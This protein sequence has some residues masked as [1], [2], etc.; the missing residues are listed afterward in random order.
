MKR[1]I[2]GFLGVV[3][4]GTLATA[5]AADV[6]PVSPSAAMDAATPAALLPQNI[7]QNVV[8]NTPAPRTSTPA[9]AAAAQAGPT[10]ARFVCLDMSLQCF[11][12]NSTTADASS[13]T[14]AP[15]ALD[16][17]A[18][19]IRG[20]VSEAELRQ[21]VEEDWVIREREE[22]QQVRV[23][24]AKPDVYVPSGIAALPWAVMNPKQAWRIF[25]PV[26]QAK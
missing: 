15:R 4:L 5:A 26:P 19:D 9:P 13:A 3:A 2:G 20:L 24:A 1:L 10:P 8:Q 17:R 6:A 7:A 18:P 25:L 22:E 12:V 16:L 21:R 11:K 14:A 23:E